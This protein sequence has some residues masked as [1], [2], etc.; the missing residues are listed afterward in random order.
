M[1]KQNTDEE[2][3]EFMTTKTAA[4]SSFSETTQTFPDHNDFTNKEDNAFSFRRMQA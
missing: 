4:H 3:I 2:G 1:I